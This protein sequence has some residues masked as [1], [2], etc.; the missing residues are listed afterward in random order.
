MRRLA[1]SCCLQL[2][3]P[4]AVGWPGCL[5]LEHPSDSLHGCR[6]ALVNLVE[7]R[8]SRARTEIARL[9][10]QQAALLQAP[11]QQGE[12]SSLRASAAWGGVF[13]YAQVQGGACIGEAGALQMLGA[14][15]ARLTWRSHV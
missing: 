13:E 8:I 12:A 15:E 10:V 7:A 9:K 6:Y 5:S 4:A 1:D 2:L 3:P 14:W 11:V